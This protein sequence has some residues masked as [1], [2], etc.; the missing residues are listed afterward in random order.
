MN[1]TI[2]GVDLAKNVIQVC[3]YA[4]KKVQSNTEMRRHEF[5]EWLFNTSGTTVVFEACGT[6][7]YWKQKALEAGHAA[8]LISAQ[9][10]STIGRQTRTMHWQL[11]RHHCCR[12]L[13]S[14]K[15]KLLSNNN[16]NPYYA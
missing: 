16:Y 3:V 8:H 10:V 5:L 1:N 15:A 13:V 7:N 2:V 11:F 12:V 14:L 9:L 4:N 6:S